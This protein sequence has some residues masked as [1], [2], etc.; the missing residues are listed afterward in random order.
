MLLRQIDL[1]RLAASSPSVRRFFPSEYGTNIKH[2]PAS[3]TE[4][5][6][7]AKL[8][9]RHVLED[10]ITSGLEYTYIVTGPWADA[11]YPAYLGPLE[12]FPELGS[13]NVKERKAV[14]VGD[15]DENG[16]WKGNNISMTTTSE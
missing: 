8:Q 10:E 5:V 6:N 14:L 7:Q 1:I 16:A 15:L 3:A 12:D 2:S 4:I 13:F 9:V 11:D